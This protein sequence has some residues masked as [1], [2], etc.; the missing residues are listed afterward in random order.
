VDEAR[1]IG[2]LYGY[3]MILTHIGDAHLE[4]GRLAEARR[5]AEEALQI[6]RA[7]GERGDEAWILHLLGGI[8]V[9]ER[10]EPV[11]HAAA[12]LELAL[13]RAEALEMRPLAA[14]CHLELGALYRVAGRPEAARRRLERAIALLREMEM[15]FWLATAERE[16]A[17]LR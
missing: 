11:E 16:L 6:A 2:L 13:A 4:A 10:A 8:D 14:R 9:A 1:A 3:S 15:T 5:P 17:A 12:G 7:H